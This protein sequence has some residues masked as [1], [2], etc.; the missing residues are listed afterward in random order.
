MFA[1]FSFT[2]VKITAKSSSLLRTLSM[3][4]LVLKSLQKALHNN[5]LSLFPK[6]FSQFLLCNQNVNCSSSNNGVS[7]T[8]F[9]DL[10]EETTAE[11]FSRLSVKDLIKSSS[12]NKAW[13]SLINNPS[14]ISSQIRKLLTFVMIMLC[15]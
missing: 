8:T 4:T 12:V 5:P 1:G 6:P 2:L 3:F 14:F 10:P 9:H 11:I 7:T 13:Y 15:L